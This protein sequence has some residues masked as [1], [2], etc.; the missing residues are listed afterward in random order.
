MNSRDFPGAGLVTLRWDNPAGADVLVEI[1]RTSTARDV[2]EALLSLAYTIDGAENDTKGLC[3]VVDSRLSSARLGEE[4]N[5]FRAI[6]RPRVANAVYLAAASSGLKSTVTGVLP[7]DSPGF[8]RAL[9]LAIQQEVASTTAGRVTRQQIKAALVE[10]W[11][12]GLPPLSIAEIRRQTGASYQTVSAALHEL[13]GM[14]LVGEERDG[15]IAIRPISPAGLLKLADEHARARKQLRFADPTGH[16]R[17]P[18]AMAERLIAL[19][20]RKAAGNVALSGVLGASRYFEDLDIT[21]APRLDLCVY[22]ANTQFVAKLDAGLVQA[23]PPRRGSKPV[24]VLHLQRDCRPLD[25]SHAPM[26]AARLDCLAD[27]EEMGLQAE[28]NGFARRLCE[29]ARSAP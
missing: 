20:H 15:P 28:A 25:A 9:Q 17:A 2:R 24:L 13:H 8:H 3:V 1:R 10:R 22:D 12:T 7:N 11:L 29:M 6:V 21:A 19:R 4:L 16:A 14:G 23:D 26:L 27:L 5:R 18:A